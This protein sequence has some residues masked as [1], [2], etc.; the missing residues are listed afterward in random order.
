M[1]DFNKYTSKIDY[2]AIIEFALQNGE[3]MHYKKREYF[4]RQGEVCYKMGYVVS[5]SFRYCCIN[6]AGESK[7][8]GYTFENSFVGNY[9]AC[10]LEDRSNVEIQALCDC[11]VYV[12]SNKQITQFYEQNIENQRLSRSI[13]ETLLWEVY[14]RMIAMYSMTP[15]ERY[16]EILDRCPALLNLISLK[17]L[18]SYLMI[19]PETLSRL[20]RK[21]V[22]K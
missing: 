7:V 5:G 9:P 22:Q 18:A 13:A 20:R 19:C 10:R 3:L 11:S 15:E 14:D 4:N 6:S 17:E 21:L 8:V 16:I 12:V 1:S 2:S